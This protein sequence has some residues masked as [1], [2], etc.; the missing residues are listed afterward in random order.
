[1]AG[2]PRSASASAATEDAAG[3][4]GGE[5]DAGV[6][7]TGPS[8]SKQKVK[9]GRKKVRNENV[10]NSK[11]GETREDEIDESCKCGTRVKNDAHGGIECDVCQKWFHPNCEELEDE[12]V[13]AIGK[14]NLF[15]MCKG[16]K[17]FLD[18]FRAVVKGTKNDQ[19][20]QTG[21]Q[22]EVKGVD[23]VDKKVMALSDNLDNVSKALLEQRK[24]LMEIG[25][26]VKLQG[27]KSGKDLEA[28]VKNAVREENVTYADMVKK[29]SSQFDSSSA[30]KS[31]TQTRELRNTVVD[32]LEQ[33]KRR[34]NVVIFNVPEAQ[35]T[36]LSREAEASMDMKSVQDLLMRGLKLKLHP[37][38]VTRVGR[39]TTGK[40]RL[41]VVTMQDESEKWELLKMAKQLRHAGAEFEKIY[42]APD[43]SPAE[44]LRDRNLRKELK[45]RKEAGE[46]VIIY[47][48]K[49][50]QRR[51]KPTGKPQEY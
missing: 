26:M 43:L 38:K 23:E 25:T 30:Q 3:T 2:R 21:G 48:H 37:V 17:S 35:D 6:D 49:V 8:A 1:M 36:N 34:C 47:K 20:Q 11:L 10:K 13:T 7:N 4:S 50:I 32:C 33:D 9:Y 24:V 16:C 12:S 14:H 46:D 28:V 40:N 39:P 44:Q 31:G 18:E 19:S 51:E 45:S 41:M 29:L 42:V 15:W 22:S 27:E 5:N